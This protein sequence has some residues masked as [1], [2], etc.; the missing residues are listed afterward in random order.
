MYIPTRYRVLSMCSRWYNNLAVRLL[1]LFLFWYIT[2]SVEIYAAWE[3]GVFSYNGVHDRNRGRPGFLFFSRRSK[4]IFQQKYLIYLQCSIFFFC[5][6]LY[7]GPLVF[8]FPRFFDSV[9][10]F[11]ISIGS[12]A[13]VA[14]AGQSLARPFLVTTTVIEI[15]H[16]KIIDPFNSTFLSHLL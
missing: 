7:R 1:L 6:F 12:V 11:S 14:A 2:K 8:S 4:I 16:C 9:N 13:A 3:K 15:V 10:L 5:L